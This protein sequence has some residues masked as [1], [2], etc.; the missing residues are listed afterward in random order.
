MF[1]FFCL[2]SRVV[3]PVSSATPRGSLLV[4]FLS[5]QSRAMEVELGLHCEKPKIGSWDNV[6]EM[7]ATLYERPPGLVTDGLMK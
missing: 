7:S 3:P 1:R 6:D 2:D 5:R 4:S